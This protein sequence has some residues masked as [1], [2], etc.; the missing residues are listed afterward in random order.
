MKKIAVIPNIVKDKNLEVTR[1]VIKSLERYTEVCTEKALTGELLPEYAETDSVLKSDCAVVIGGD[2]TILQAAFECAKA[3][4]PI[5]GVNLGKIGFMTEVEISEIDKAVDSLVNGEY[6]TEERMMLKAEF[7]IEGKKKVYHALNDVVLSK[8]DKAKLIN[9]DLFSGEDL[10]NRYNADGLIIATPTGSTGYSLS[11]G[12]P[13][14]NPLMELFIATPMCAHMLTA[15]T[16]IMPADEELKAVLNSENGGCALISIDGEVVGKIHNLETVSITKSCY[17]T[18]II[19]IKRQ[20]FYSV[21]IG[22]LS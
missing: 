4:I 1:R 7:D 9:M 11:A 8:T 10:I 5:L 14:V 15:R 22:K 12:G 16:A 21:F 20:S 6:V 18:K 13:V 17:K 3:D 2:G 19:K